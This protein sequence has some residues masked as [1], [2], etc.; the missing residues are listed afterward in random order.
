MRILGITLLGLLFITNIVLNAIYI[1]LI[2]FNKYESADKMMRIK[3]LHSL[4]CIMFMT[5][6]IIIM[7]GSFN[8]DLDFDLDLSGIACFMIFYF[9][10][11]CL[12]DYK[13]I[14]KLRKNK[15]YKCPL[16]RRLL[17]FADI[18]FVT[19]NVYLL[20]LGIHHFYILGIIYN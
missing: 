6:S 20:Y 5:W 4:I 11:S 10:I 9:V 13:L 17:V 12:M 7:N 16:H 18:I 2:N 1:A 15:W 19:V 8:I 3:T 14:K